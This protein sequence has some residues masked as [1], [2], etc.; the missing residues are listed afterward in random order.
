MKLFRTCIM[1]DNFVSSFYKLYRLYKTKAFYIQSRIHRA[2]CFDQICIV[3]LC[4]NIGKSSTCNQLTRSWSLD[5]YRVFRHTFLRV[6]YLLKFIHLWKCIIQMYYIIN[7]YI[8]CIILLQM[9][10]YYTAYYCISRAYFIQQIVRCNDQLRL[11]KESIHG[12]LIKSLLI[13]KY[14]ICRYAFS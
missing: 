5:H 11:V 8:Y 14:Q 2:V 1:V 13:I 12:C 7:I 6:I 9:K 10:M 4:P 3:C